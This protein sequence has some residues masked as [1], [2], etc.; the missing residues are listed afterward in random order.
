M[1]KEKV[2]KFRQDSFEECTVTHD[3]LDMRLSGGPHNEI[4]PVTVGDK[5]LVL[6]LIVIR[7]AFLQAERLTQDGQAEGGTCSSIPKALV[8][9]NVGTFHLTTP[10]PDIGSVA[11]ASGV[12]ASHGD[13]ECTT[14]LDGWM[15][16]AGDI[17]K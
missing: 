10:V 6:H 15:V 1:S 5:H 2:M 11:K 14:K 4:S 12:A 17:C 3:S 8:A 13:L 9:A 7:V 16:N